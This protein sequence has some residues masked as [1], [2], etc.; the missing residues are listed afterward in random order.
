MHMK[1]WMVYYISPD[2]FREGNEVISADT[3]AEALSHYRSFFNVTNDLV[4]KAIPIY[5]EKN[6][7]K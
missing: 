7:S 2:G 5:G 3:R 4:C 1:K 6:G